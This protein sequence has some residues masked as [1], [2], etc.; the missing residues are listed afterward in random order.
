MFFLGEFDE[1]Y[2]RYLRLD[3]CKIFTKMTRN[4]NLKTLQER[5][6]TLGFAVLMAI[7]GNAFSQISGNVTV[8]SGGTYSS[9]TDLATAI[10]SS[11]VNGALNVTVTSD[12]NESAIVYL[13]K[14]AS[15]PPTSTNTITIDGKGFKLRS[16]GANAAIIFDG[17][18]YTT[19]KNLTVEKYTTSLN[20]KGIQFM[21]NAQYNTV[22][23][24]NIE[25]ALLASGTTSSASGGAYIVFSQSATTMASAGTVPAGS[26][27]TISNCLMR[28]TNS[29]SPGPYAA[30][31]DYGSSSWN[32]ST[33][34]NNTIKGNTIENF[35][36]F[37][38][39][40]YY[41]NG[42]QFINNDI[43][44]ANA[45][46]N[47]AY[48]VAYMMYSYYTRS[49]NRSTMY[50][51]NK[52]HDLPYKGA[53]AKDAYSSTVYGIYA[54]YN[55]GTAANNFMVKDN[56][57]QNIEC[58]S[59]NYFGYCYYNYYANY[60][61]NFV[62]NWNSASTS[63]Y[64]YGWYMY[65]QYNDHIFRNN[66]IRDCRTSYYTYFVY[67]YYGDKKIFTNNKITNNTTAQGST[68]YTYCFYIYY[69]SS[70]AV[71]IFEDNVLDSNTFGYATLLWKL[72]CTTGTVSIT[73]IRIT[74]NRII[75]NPTYGISL[76][77][78]L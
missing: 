78:H 72:Y 65:Y 22:D 47:N 15:L 24:C 60:D 45:T 7:S 35:Y 64:L 37:G 68:G 76:W 12:L 26:Y 66:T 5:F 51:G 41:T 67:C 6:K 43:S 36:Y 71:N 77:I 4:Y 46:S 33:P 19:L 20:Q 50:E 73:E 69:P 29:N 11:G 14:N 17:I 8:G 2:H 32:T 27:N 13:R 28:T 21:N 44:R 59:T 38:V 16:T 63:S 3:N 30:I 10:S 55:Y 18:S 49:T 54:Y 39:Y 61:G 53:T 34:S 42:D 75:D 52:F 62:Q 48:S 56:A 31:V 58:A 40:N 70:S 23:K 74:N 57:F 1:I 25:F 9:L